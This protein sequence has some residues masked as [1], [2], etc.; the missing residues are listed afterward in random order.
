MNSPSIYL[1]LFSGSPI[2]IILLD[3]PF[4]SKLLLN[5]LKV[6]NQLYCGNG[7]ANR[8]Y[9]LRDKPEFM[10]IMPN[11]IIGDMHPIHNDTKLYYAKKNV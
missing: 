8:L 4:N 1:K 2:I 10:H 3:A 6:P 5:L 9:D 7:G 11:Y